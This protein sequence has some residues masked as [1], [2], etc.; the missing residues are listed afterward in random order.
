MLAGVKDLRPQGWQFW[1]ET[2]FCDLHFDFAWTSDNLWGPTKQPVR[3][4][5]CVAWH[6]LSWTLYFLEFTR[7]WD[8]GDSLQVANDLKAEQYA[9]AE[10]AT[11]CS[12]Q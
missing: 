1:Y 5:D 3:L 12:T 2:P 6:E 7:A 4:P 8:E 11:Q 10:E 9:A